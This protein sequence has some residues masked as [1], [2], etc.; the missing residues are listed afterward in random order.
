MSYDVHAV[1]AHFPSLAG[2]T[3]YFDGPGGT[4]TPDTVGDA[5]RSTL[6]GPLSNRGTVTA[7]ERHAEAAVHGARQAMA[8]LIG[9]SG[10][11]I[12][13]G[14]SATALHYIL[15]RA[16]AKTWGPG[17]EILVSR[18]DHDSHIRPWIQAADATGASVR[19]IP[20]DPDTT[21]LTADQ[22]AAQLTD[23]T[24]LVAVTGASNLLGTRP[25]IPAIARAVHGCGALLS[26]DGVHLTAH[27]A[28]DLPALGADFYTCSPYKF[29]GP[30]CGV[31]AAD[32]ELLAEVYPDK[33][34]PAT[35]RVPERFEFGTLPYELL[36]GVT[37]AVD[38]LAGL[39]PAAAGTR[40]ERLATSLAAAFAHEDALRARIEGGLK[41]L[42]GV[43]VHS[44]A[45]Q[46]TPTLLVTFADHDEAAA[47][48]FLAERNINAP[49]G[50]FYALE[51]S[52]QLG[53]G[54][55]G[56]LRIGLAPYTIAEDADRLLIALGEFLAG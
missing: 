11:G 30:H 36:A 55:A 46:R 42:P 16:L 39:D 34:L 47:Y 28:I 32:P 41:A 7:A 22:V 20:F 15:S 35:D 9:A 14:R 13:F 50:N 18:L 31:L 51:P 53:L 21:E 29:L 17:D 5:V 8:D 1:R 27:A 12:V 25:D 4:Q 43:T 48:R 54:D 38:F 6:I 49:A 37:A 33:L 10:D 23:N 52:R 2:G 44:R 3:A 40:R 19:W 56:G 24:R 45:A 26:V